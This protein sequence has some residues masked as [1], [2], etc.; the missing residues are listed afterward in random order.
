MKGI[1]LSQLPDRFRSKFDTEWEMASGKQ[2]F[3]V[4]GLK[5]SPEFDSLKEVHRYIATLETG[6]LAEYIHRKYSHYGYAKG[7]PIEYNPE[8]I[9]GEKQDGTLPKYIPRDRYRWVEN[10]TD[11]LRWVGK[12]DDLIRLDHTGYYTDNFQDE[13]VHGEVYQMPARNGEPVYIPAVND[14]CNENCACLDFTSTTSDKEDA[15][16]WADSM[17]EK[18]AEMEREY[19][20]EESRKVRLE[21]IGEEIQGLYQEFRRVSR[22]L[23]ANCDKVA[24][25]QV[26]REL[27][28]R[29]WQRT[30]QSIHKLRAERERV[31]QY[32][33][34]Y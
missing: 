16:R 3:F 31:D 14:P 25:V 32:G 2:Q 28:R 12:S 20:A 21:E 15:A 23:R 6:A 4:K 24:G 30:K 27:V 8:F 18:W 19:Q 1:A 5:D 22:E 33:I 7:N 11:G 9:P 29:E 26:V 34:E 17:A 10:V 13:T